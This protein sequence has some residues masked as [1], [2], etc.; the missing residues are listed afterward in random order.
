MKR[1][2]KIIEFRKK[3]K[4]RNYIFL[5]HKILFIVYILFLFK[6]EDKPIKQIEI[7]N[8]NQFFNTTIK[9]NS[10][11][12]FENNPYHYECTPGYTKYFL[13]LGFDIDIIMTSEGK[14]IFF[15]LGKIRI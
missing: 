12:I 4:T 2:E 9:P 3:H 6:Y 13:D 5:K 7:F 1:I 14:G 15:F 8:I 10:I 11:L